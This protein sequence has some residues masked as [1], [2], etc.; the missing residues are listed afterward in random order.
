MQDKSKVTTFK[1]P[2]KKHQPAGLS[3]LYED[4]DI[5]VVDKVEGLLTM[6]T[7]REKHRTAHFLLN[8]YVKKGNP[9]AKNRVFIVHRL[10]RDTSGVL[11]F[12]K[13]EDAK[14]YL[15]EH[16]K[17]FSKVYYAVVA[18]KLQDKEGIITSYLVENKA[19]RMYS[20][21]DPEQ[22]KFSK[23][24]YRVIKETS[25]CSLLEID[26]YT[27][28]KNQIRVHLS[29]KGNPVLGD[30]VYGQADRL[31]KRL[32]LHAASLTII[33][34]VTKKEMSFKTEIPP[35]FKTLVKA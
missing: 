15:Q 24:G 19:K 27:G 28:R 20:S 3:I 29:D 33:H 4:K 17:E 34:P 8:E 26:L 5:L 18:G 12:A 1:K 14:Q 23:T 16:W 6:G 10:D 13:N 35:Y 7:D 2:S 30:K 25:R 21:Q 22:G 31:S 9:R 32:A 11:V